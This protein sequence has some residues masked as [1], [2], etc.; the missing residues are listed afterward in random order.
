MELVTKLIEQGMVT[1]HTT[2]QGREYITP[3]QIEREVRLGALWW[4]Q[5]EHTAHMLP[6]QV[7]ME[8]ERN[9]GRMNLT[10]MTTSLF[11]DLSLIEKAAKV[12]HDST[13]TYGRTFAQLTEPLTVWLSGA[14]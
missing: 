11:L 7:H 12:R 8:V 9:G 5:C 4:C 3:E 1:L 10:D 2:T 13:N 6:G 14:L